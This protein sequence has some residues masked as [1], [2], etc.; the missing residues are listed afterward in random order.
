T[1]PLA[2]NTTPAETVIASTNAPAATNHIEIFSDSAEFLIE[3]NIAVYTGNVRAFY[4]DTKMTCDVLTLHVPKGGERP[5]YMVADRKVVIDAKDKSG[6]PIHATGDKA[7]YTY[8]VEDGT[9]NEVMVL[10]GDALIRSENGSSMR[11]DPVIWN[12]SKGTVNVIT[13]HMIIQQTPKEASTN[14]PPA[15]L[16]NTNTP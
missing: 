16:S 4:L 10:S 9:T 3:T 8:K 11:G 13:P 1:E 15:S 7:V 2:T 6:K 12:L 14:K 5:D